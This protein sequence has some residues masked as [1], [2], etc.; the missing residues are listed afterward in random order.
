MIRKERFKTQII[1]HVFNKSIANFGIFKSPNNAQRFIELLDYYNT[2]EVKNRFSKIKKKNLYHYKNLLIPH[3]NQQVKF[4]GFNIMPDHYHLLIKILINNAF[5]KYINDVE[6]S[7][8]RFFNIKHR[9]KGPLWQS[10]FKAVRIRTNEQLLHVSRYI[11]L[12]ATTAGLVAKPEDWLFS[13][14]KDLIF[15]NRFLGNFIKEISITDPKIYRRFVENNQEYQKKLK[16]IK[17]LILEQS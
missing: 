16:Q 6:N 10:S 4:I 2:T 13:S 14:Y 7:F 12:N 11:N 9:R 3:Q 17:R 1:F 5:S 8:T 15:D